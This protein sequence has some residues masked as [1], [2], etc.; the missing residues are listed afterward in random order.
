MYLLAI[1][2]ECTAL[3]LQPRATTARLAQSRRARGACGATLALRR[4]HRAQ[5]LALRRAR[6]HARASP[7]AFSSAAGTRPPT[8]RPTKNRTKEK[9]S[10]VVRKSTCLTMVVL[11]G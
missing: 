4:A 3:R 10:C 8:C 11:N 6:A 5:T 1:H 9:E 7:T 2:G